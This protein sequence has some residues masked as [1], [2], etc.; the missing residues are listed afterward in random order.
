M[1]HV[2]AAAVLMPLA[3]SI[4]DAMPPKG[5]ILSAVRQAFLGDLQ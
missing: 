2:A 3:T 1:H 4:C 5:P